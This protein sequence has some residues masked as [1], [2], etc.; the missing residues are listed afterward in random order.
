G[1]L[2]RRRAVAA[3]SGAP[4][5]V[6]SYYGIPYDQSSEAGLIHSAWNHDAL[7]NRGDTHAATLVYAASGRHPRLPCTRAG[8][9]RGVGA[10]TDARRHAHGWVQRRHQDARPDVLRP[11]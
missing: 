8:D 11:V 6:D 2:A 1:V 4:L 10:D 3:V 7:E 5:G 9:V